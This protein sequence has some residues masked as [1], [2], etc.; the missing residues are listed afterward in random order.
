M[1]R[2]YWS[3]GQ[4]VLAFY[5]GTA[6]VAVFAVAIQL[7]LLYMT[8]S[9]AISGVFLPRLT[10]MVAQCASDTEMSRLFLRTGRIQ[11]MVM[12]L[13]LSGFIVFGRSFV[14]LW[15]GTGY[16]D[17]YLIT[18]IFFFALTIPMIQNVGIGILQARNRLKFRSLLYLLIASISLLMQFLLAPRY[19]GVGVA[20]AIAGALLV[21]QGVAMN[22]YYHYRQKLDIQAFWRSIGRMSVV[23]L[24]MS[25]GATLSLLRVS[26]STWGGLCLAICVYL[27]VYVPLFWRWSMNGEERAA[28]RAIIRKR[29]PI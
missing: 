23:P 27:C 17:T 13:V 24:L 25:I 19:G 29:L 4:M 12:A 16:D 10:T 28:V 11:Y 8:F 15:A 18:L 20:C 7:S 14:Y 1:D 21:G 9:T 3:T 2:I 5:D 22:L 26:L 6:Q